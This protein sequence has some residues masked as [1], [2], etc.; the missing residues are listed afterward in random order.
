MGYNL[1]LL[2]FL[3]VATLTIFEQLGAPFKLVF[4]QCLVDL[5]F[6]SLYHLY[7]CFKKARIEKGMEAGTES[8]A[9]MVLRL[10]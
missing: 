10:E 3:W 6:G 5:G 2:L 8:D 9:D 7:Y 1:E 4:N